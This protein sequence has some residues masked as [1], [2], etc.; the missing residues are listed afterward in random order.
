MGEESGGDVLGR[1]GVREISLPVN[2]AY[3]VLIKNILNLKPG[4]QHEYKTGSRDMSPEMR[5]SAALY[6]Y[7]IIRPRQC[8]C[9]FFFTCYI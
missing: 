1:G 4:E 7:I 5:T 2:T 3:A 9:F 6:A 8:C